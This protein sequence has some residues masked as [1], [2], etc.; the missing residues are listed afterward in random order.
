MA[1]KPRME[2]ETAIGVAQEA[3]GRADRMS[4][5]AGD[6]ARKGLQ[7]GM[8]AASET[9]RQG[10]EQASEGVRYAADGFAAVMR[11]SSLMA[12]ATQTVSQE[13]FAY[14]QAALRRNVEGMGELARCRSFGDLLESQNDLLKRQ[15]DELAQSSAR[16]SDR[17][18]SA[19]QEAAREIDEA[20][21]RG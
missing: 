12:G 10:V 2:A 17:L 15:L 9:A 4:E 8:E 3:F 5:E 11:L 20:S 1:R 21:P 14:T 19:A 6:A 16:M 7:G 13:W 18:M